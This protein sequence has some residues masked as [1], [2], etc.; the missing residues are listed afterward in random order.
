M[1]CMSI[2]WC[3]VWKLRDKQI[4][5]VC[6]Q[7]FPLASMSSVSSSVTWGTWSCSLPCSS[8]PCSAADTWLIGVSSDRQRKSMR[9]CSDAP[10][11]ISEHL[12]PA[13]L[14]SPTHLEVQHLRVCFSMVLPTPGGKLQQYLSN[15]RSLQLYCDYLILIFNVITHANLS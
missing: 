5:A 10:T 4:S 2:Q 11:G 9:P 14:H 6:D 12:S 13:Q 3:D 15:E 1:Y 8:H 7:I